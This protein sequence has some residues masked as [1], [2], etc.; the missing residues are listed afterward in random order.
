[1]DP[2]TIGMALS[3][4]APSLIKLF[5]GS[6]RAAE[7]AEKVVDVAK[8]V[9]GAQTGEAALEE[10][11]ANPDKLLEFR[12]AIASKQ[13]DLEKAYLADIADARR[14]DTAFIQSG[15]RNM[16][17]DIMVGV[18]AIGLIV[19]LVVLAVYRQQLS[20]EVIA[21]ISTIASIF[22]LC[23]RDA[24]Q[25][26]FGSSRGSRDKDELISKASIK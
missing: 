7:V 23:L 14:R 17:A 1:M 20:G 15:Q 2:I 18:D 4:F 12:E 5:S 6:D 9:T 22:G 8:A 3:Q 16:R 19:C 11:K 13:A 10:I 21:L 26:E 25:F 24:H